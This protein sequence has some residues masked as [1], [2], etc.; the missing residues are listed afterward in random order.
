MLPQ[1]LLFLLGLEVR[2]ITGLPQA[3]VASSPPP[4]NQAFPSE[5]H[6]IARTTEV[7][8]A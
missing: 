2:T 7:N 4:L 1:L 3:I 6:D 8:V 5:Y